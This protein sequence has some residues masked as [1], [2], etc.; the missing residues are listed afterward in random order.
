MHKTLILSI[1]ILRSLE[2]TLIGAEVFKN[3]NGVLVAQSQKLDKGGVQ[4]KNG[5]FGQSFK[6]F[7][8][9]V[10]FLFL[11]KIFSLLEIEIFSTKNTFLHSL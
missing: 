11:A 7:L 3:W 5:Q 8:I 4:M 2:Q 9:F 1:E 10:I 6:I